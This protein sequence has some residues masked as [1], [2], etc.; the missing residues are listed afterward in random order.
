VPNNPNLNPNRTP[1]PLPFLFLNTAITADGKIAPASGR[2]VPF[3]SPRDARHMLELRATADAVMSGARTVNSFPVNMGPGPARYRR[4]RLKRGLAEYNLRVIV[5]GTGTI[6]PCA[7]IFRHRFSP[8]IILTTNRISQTKLRRLRAVAD[9]VKIF[10]SQKLNL[11]GALRWLKKKWG[12]SRLLCEGGGE[13]NAALFQA[14]L[15]HEAHLTIC[16][17][18]F[19]GR[20]SPTLAGGAGIKHLSDAARFQLVSMQRAAEEIFL[21]Y[22]A[23]SRSQAQKKESCITIK[24]CSER[25]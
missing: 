10:E 3:G 7:E 11:S 9:E 1:P 13:L 12:V 24:S 17:V 22:R 20:H 6:D 14:G 25:A 19:G 5:S 21:V 8:I 4:L 15:V 2:Y 23:Q 16:P 18:I